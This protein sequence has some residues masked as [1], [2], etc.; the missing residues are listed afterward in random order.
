MGAKSDGKA[1]KNRLRL[2]LWPYVHFG[3]RAWGHPKSGGRKAATHMEAI[4]M[5][6]LLITATAL[7]MSGAAFAYQ[8]APTPQTTNP[9]VFQSTPPLGTATQERAAK[10]QQQMQRQMQGQEHAVEQH[11]AD[12]DYSQTPQTSQPNIYQSTP[13]LG[14]ASQERA[15][16]DARQQ[17]VQNW[18]A[19]Q[20]RLA[21][22]HWTYYPTHWTAQQRTTY[23]Q[24]MNMPA[25]SW[26]PEQRA[27]YSEHM[28][29]LP[30]S[31]TEADRLAYQ[32]RISPIHTPWMMSTQT[33][34]SHPALT[35]R[36]S[37][38]T[39]EQWTS[40]QR[41][42]EWAGMGG[43]Y[44]EVYGDG[45]INLTPRPATA[46][47]PPCTPGPGDDRCIQ[48]YEPGVRTQLSQWNQPTGGL[49]GSAQV[50]MGGPYEDAYTAGHTSVTYDGVGGPDETR[51][52]YPPC[53]PGPGDDRCIQL[54]ER[55]VTGRDN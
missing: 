48:L 18:G 42:Q 23:Q 53:Q 37:D 49:S 38:W 50:G 4:S 11:H 46:N 25:T 13:P 34:Y 43:P 29:T 31:W 21:E 8:T 33:A 19:D 54:Y 40:Y 44:E 7:S 26:T 32:E 35:Q 51:T 47:Y 30:P 5:K 17:F 1:D 45:S 2:V 15:W 16:L 20:R 9:S 41:Q 27:L 55:G 6:T 24:M 10:D 22:Q 12:H 36:P 28:R 14:T 52:G 3:E 39:E